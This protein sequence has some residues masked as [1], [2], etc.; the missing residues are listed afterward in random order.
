MSFKLKL[1]MFLGVASFQQT[2]PSIGET[3]PSS[4]GFSFAQKATGDAITP[5]GASTPKTSI[6]TANHTSFNKFML[7]FYGRIEILKC[8]QVNN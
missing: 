4:L 5:L 8:S 2:R 6:K 7:E 1:V 3:A